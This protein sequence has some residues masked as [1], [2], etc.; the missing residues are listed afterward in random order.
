MKDGAK[1]KHRSKGAADQREPISVHAVAAIRLLILTG[2]RAGEILNLQ[3]QHVDSER[4][5]LNLPDS[6]TGAKVVVLAA[7]A[8]E[9]LGNIPRV[10]DNPY[11]IAGDKPKQPRSDLKRPWGRITRR[12]GLDGVR[13]HDL[14]HT[15]ASAGAG[16]GMGLPIVGKLLGHASQATTARYAHLADNPLRQGANLIAGTLASQLARKGGEV[17]PLRKDEAV[18]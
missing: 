6:K 3:W 4:G 14:R 15:F 8:L 17:V 9:V 1:E 11:V 7:P 16:A 2:C 5:F 12:A 18:G 10:K 13:L